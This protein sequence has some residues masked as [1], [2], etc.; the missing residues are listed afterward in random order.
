VWN[1][2]ETVIWETTKSLNNSYS[3]TLVLELFPFLIYLQ[4]AILD[5]AFSLRV[6]SVARSGG[7]A[8]APAM[9]KGR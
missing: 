7:A 1:N 8:V 2:S 6:K 4:A 3:A 9:W 5:L